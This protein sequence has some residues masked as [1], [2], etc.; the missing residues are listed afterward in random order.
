MTQPRSTL[1]DFDSFE[2]IGSGSFGVVYRVRRKLDGRIYALKQVA[3]SSHAQYT[4]T[5]KEINIL[6]SLNH[7][8]IVRYYDCFSSDGDTKLN[9]VMEYA[10]HGTLHD[11]IKVRSFC[12]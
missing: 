3:L 7:T 6:A 9:I 4:E 1:S 8:H 11:M 12:L 5:V 2:Q 10:K